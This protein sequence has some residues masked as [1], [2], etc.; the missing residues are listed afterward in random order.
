MLTQSK[1]IVVMASKQELT[2]PHYYL[3]LWLAF[4]NTPIS[5][6]KWPDRIS[7]TIYGFDGILLCS[8]GRPW[9][10]PNVDDVLGDPRWI[11]MLQESVD[12][13]PR[14]T[15]IRK[16]EA[17]RLIDGTFRIDEPHIARHFGR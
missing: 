4:V 14:R 1:R 2:D 16:I 17:L 10:I 6:R 8:D 3:R 12:G 9:P 13:K 5:R 11:S 15:N 7:R